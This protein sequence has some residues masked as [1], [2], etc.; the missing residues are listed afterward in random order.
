MTKRAKS[1]GANDTS[2]VNAS[3]LPSPEH[4]DGVA[5]NLLE[6]KAM[7]DVSKDNAEPPFSFAGWSQVSAGALIYYA[8]YLA[9]P[10][11]GGP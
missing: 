10:V 5:A 4:T 7:N 8:L 9:I 11:H 2:F 6:L 1:I 3:G